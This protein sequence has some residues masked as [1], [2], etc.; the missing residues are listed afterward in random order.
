MSTPET[1][2][3][4]AARHGARY[5]W[6]V[7]ITTLVGLFSAVTTTTIV[8][9][10]IPDIMGA[11]GIGQDE[12][13]WFSSGALAGTSVAMLMQAW[14]VGRFGPRATFTGANIVFLS[15]L[16]VAGFAPNQVV[17]VIAR[18]V[19]GSIAGVLQPLAVYMLFRAFP[20]DRKG[21]AMGMFGLVAIAGPAFGPIVGGVMIEHFNW[22]SIFFVAIPTS[23]AALLLGAMFLP[24]REAG[25]GAVKRFDWLS[26]GLVSLSLGSLLH[27]LANGQRDGWDSNRSYATLAVALAAGFVFVV[28]ELRSPAPLV[29]LRPLAIPRFAATVAVSCIFGVGLFGTVYLVPLFLQTVQGFTPVAAGM[30]LMLPGVVMGM[31]MPFAGFLADRLAASTLILAGVVLSIVSAAWVSGVDV[32]TP[33][34]VFAAWVS[35]GRVGIGLVNPAL[36]LAAMKALPPERLAQAAGLVNFSRQLGGAFGVNLLAMTLDR[37]AALHID[38][39]NAGQA[40]SNATPELLRYVESMLRKSGAWEQLRSDGALHYLGRVIEAQAYSIAFQDS[41]RFVAFAF[42]VALVPAAIIAVAGRRG[43]TQV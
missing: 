16:L 3:V 39:F 18:V 29:D 9:V 31:T 1:L 35:V 43:P 41:F 33:F 17:L 23:A 20:A 30:F 26:L 28:R 25:A 6:W 42:G 8:N 15:S 13:Q 32:N 5:R 12:A 7:A 27:A 34:F 22:R 21:Q 40:D 36:N 10:A 11:F 37:R 19:Q 4:L 38:A 14:L 2:E 24:Q